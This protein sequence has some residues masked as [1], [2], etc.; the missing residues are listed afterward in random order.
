MST[1]IEFDFNKMDTAIQNL[2]GIVK[3]VKDSLS[4]F[5]RLQDSFKN[6]KGGTL[7]ENY[8]I[9]RKAIDSY[10]LEIEAN[11][12]WLREFYKELRDANGSLESSAFRLLDGV[13]N[14]ESLVD[15]AGDTTSV[16]KNSSVPKESIDETK[17]VDV[18]A[19]DSEIRNKSGGVPSNA[20]EKIKNQLSSATLR[21]EL[22]S[23][24]KQEDIINEEKNSSEINAENITINNIPT[25][26]NH[27]C[28]NI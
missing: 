17:Q 27:V 21:N 12:D 14:A 7:F 26:K 1:S 2:N 4:G 3:D 20:K 22:I 6:Y 28:G 15:V 18:I 10:G 13:E 9:T 11:R 16:L 19:V 8:F 24:L 25:G 5:Y 23:G